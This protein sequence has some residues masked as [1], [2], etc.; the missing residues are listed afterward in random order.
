MAFFAAVM[1]GGT[2]LPVILLEVIV[3]ALLG[4]C[5]ALHI[6]HHYRGLPVLELVNELEGLYHV[7]QVVLVPMSVGVL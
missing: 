3:V 2:F 4:K 6:W 5:S 7:L 1:A